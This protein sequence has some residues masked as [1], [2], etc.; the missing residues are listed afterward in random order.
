M[1]LQIDP[2]MWVAVFVAAVIALDKNVEDWLELQVKRLIVWVQSERLKR[3]LL[4]EIKSIEAD[5]DRWLQ[6]CEQIF[7]NHPTDD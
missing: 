4:A 5:Y 6:D 7:P 2:L 1:S 3:Q